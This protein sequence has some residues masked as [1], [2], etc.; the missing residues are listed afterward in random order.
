MPGGM[1]EQPSRPMIR[2]AAERLDLADCPPEDRSS[3]CVQSSGDGP[4][5][6]ELRESRASTT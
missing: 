6:D 3:Q 4:E 2:G 1:I 5:E